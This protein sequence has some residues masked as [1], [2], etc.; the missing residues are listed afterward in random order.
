LTRTRTTDALPRLD[1]SDRRDDDTRAGIEE[2]AAEFA[3][4][5]ARVLL[6]GAMA[7]RAVSL[8]VVE[9]NPVIEP[10]LGIQAFYAMANALA[11]ARGLN[12][13]RP[14]HLNKITETV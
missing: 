6:A 14:P 10:L 2:L 4:R 8:P 12:P 13:D 7:P 3:S 9:A 11:L 5:G 1:R